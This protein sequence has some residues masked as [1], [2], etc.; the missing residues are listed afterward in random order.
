[1]KYPTN[2]VTS[3]STCRTTMDEVETYTI[4]KTSGLSLTVVISQAKSWMDHYYYV[5]IGPIK[6]FI[7]L[8]NNTGSYVKKFH[9]FDKSIKSEIYDLIGNSEISFYEDS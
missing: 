6:K 2:T 3:A 9:I 4:R 7:I 5:S 8:D 1:M